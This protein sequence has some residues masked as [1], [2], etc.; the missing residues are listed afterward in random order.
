[1]RVSTPQIAFH[2][3]DEGKNEPI[4]SVDYH[5][6]LD[7]VLTG[8]SD[9]EVKIWKFKA[10]D[11]SEIPFTFVMALAN[12]HKK[13]VNT[14][15]FSP[16]GEKAVSCS[17][18]G[19][20][21]VISCDKKKNPEANWDNITEERDVTL[22]YLRGHSGDVFD[23]AWSRD[24]QYL[25]SGS[26]DGFVFVWNVAKGKS[27]QKFDKHGHY[28]QGVSC[29]PY[30]HF[31]CSASADRTVKIYKA[32]MQKSK[33][34][35]PS[36]PA[37]KFKFSCELSKRLY[38]VQNKTA[39]LGTDP[40]GNEI[41]AID[42]TPT[43]IRKS[44]QIFMDDSVSSFFRRVDW[45]PD[46]NLLIVPCGQF[47]DVQK[48]DGSNLRRPTTYVY[49]RNKWQ[50]PAL[51][52]PGISKPS[53]GVRFNPKL[54]KLVGG[55]GAQP[56]IKLPY[57]MMFAVI[58]LDSVLLYDTQHKYPIAAAAQLHF[59]QMTD[60][61]WSADGL[62]LIVSSNDGYCSVLYFSAEEMGEMLPEDQL[63]EVVKTLPFS[64][65]IGIEDSEKVEKVPEP[66]DQTV[67][68]TM[69]TTSIRRIAPV[70]VVSGPTKSNEIA[71]K[72]A[73]P[74][75]RRKIQPTLISSPLVAA[76]ETTNTTPV[77][78]PKTE[79]M[80]EHQPSPN[81]KRRVEPIL[82]SKME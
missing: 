53:V 82:L 21:C 67:K 18:D 59:A 66:T 58:T 73:S 54:F 74:L 76:K 44:Q 41:K 5:P 40:Q 35:D 64:A 70:Q 48:K 49:L 19:L 55:D 16:C 24:S 22:T 69:S 7:V 14:V 68:T 63:P 6:S 38:T 9:N 77:L 71:P 42:T 17:D 52:L 29:D 50:S 15:R 2:G 26:I 78:A 30:G 34:E 13:S 39:P 25:V 60:I 20:L 4:L 31:F 11:E 72:T 57:R 80:S 8:G 36:I 75:V 51:Q 62:Q 27:V 56:W 10:V 46:G 1:M 61:A 45:S 81:K 33:P 47:K 12:V 28:V 3:R 32:V 23:V 43:T 79:V 65:T 37:K